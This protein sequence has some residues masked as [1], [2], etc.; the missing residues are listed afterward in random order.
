MVSLVAPRSASEDVSVASQSHAI[1]ISVGVS[2][3]RGA[4]VGE[5]STES[6][7]S[8]VLGVVESSEPVSNGSARTAGVFRLRES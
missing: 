5:R 8:L 7:R 3:M 6:L 1:L 2:R 4:W